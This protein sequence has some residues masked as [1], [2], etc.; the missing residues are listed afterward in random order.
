MVDGLED[1]KYHLTENCIRNSSGDMAIKRFIDTM[2]FMN[3]PFMNRVINKKELKI[4]TN[5]FLDQIVQ[6]SWKGM[7]SRDYEQGNLIKAFFYLAMKKKI[8]PI[9]YENIFKKSWNIFPS[10]KIYCSIMPKDFMNNSKEFIRKI[11]L[12]KGF[13]INK[14]IIINQAF[15][16]NDPTNSF[17]F[18]DNPKAIVLDRDP[19]DIYISNKLCK[20]GEGRWCPR[21]DVDSFIIFYK[22]IHHNTHVKENNVLRISFEDLIYNYKETADDIEKFTGLH[23]HISEKKYFDPQKSLVN[24]QI[25]KRFPKYDNDIKKIEEELKDYLYPFEKY[26]KIDIK[27]K[28]FF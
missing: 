10:R 12:A 18:Y 9:L 11:L 14:T 21:D 3:V 4:I 1:L 13:D 15:E 17:P 5:N 7:E 19:R 22:N 20:T 8:M 24:T 26:G 28:S 25:Y 16:G 27:N 23:N 6:T 2:N